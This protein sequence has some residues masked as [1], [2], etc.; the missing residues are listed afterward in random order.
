MPMAFISAASIFGSISRASRASRPSCRS[1]RPQLGVRR[2]CDAVRVQQPDVS[3]DAPR[4]LAGLSTSLPN[5][6]DRVGQLLLQLRH[7]RIDDRMRLRVWPGRGKEE[8]AA[9]S[10]ADTCGR[11]GPEKR[12]SVLH[13]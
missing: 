7:H 2:R 3:G 5:G 11:S 9:D 4:M 6:N 13:R 8:T 10:R 1:N 12:P